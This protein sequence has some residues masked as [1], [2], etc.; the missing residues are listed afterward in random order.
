MVAD[1]RTMIQNKRFKLMSSN[2]YRKPYLCGDICVGACGKRRLF[3]DNRPGDSRA[4]VRRLRESPCAL[5]DGT[6]VCGHCALVL[7]GKI[8]SC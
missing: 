6:L 1:A 2:K 5:S 7:G 8:T 4:V 3:G